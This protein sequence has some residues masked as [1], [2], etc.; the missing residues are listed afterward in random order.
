MKENKYSNIMTVS[1][2]LS[3]EEYESLEKIG[4]KYYTKRVSTVIKNIIRD[5]MK[6][7]EENNEQGIFVNFKEEVKAEKKVNV[8]LGT[9]T[10]E[11]VRKYSKKL[12]V[13]LYWFVRYMIFPQIKEEQQERKSV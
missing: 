3:N 8:N 1:I 12:G 5:E 4:E 13:P 2:P 9:Y 11:F 6:G 10:G 7:F